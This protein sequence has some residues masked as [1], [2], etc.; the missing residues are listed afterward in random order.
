[1]KDWKYYRTLYQMELRYVNHVNK[2]EK[3][4]Y[5]RLM[6]DENKSGLYKRMAGW[7]Q[8]HAWRSSS[9]CEVSSASDQGKYIYI[10][11]YIIVPFF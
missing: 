11:I 5:F 3:V 4:I 10:Y 1:M 2:A 8:Y 9:L 7:Y 6:K